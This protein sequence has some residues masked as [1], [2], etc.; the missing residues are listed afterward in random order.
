MQFL[1]FYPI[2]LQDRSMS[3]FKVIDL[4][5]GCGGL[6]CGFKKDFEL[7]ASLEIDKTCCETLNSNSNP[8]ELIINEDINNFQNYLPILDS[9]IN[10]NLD[11]VIGG[12]PCQAYSIAGRINPNN[13]GIRLVCNETYGDLWKINDKRYH[14]LEYSYVKDGDI[15]RIQQNTTNYK[16]TCMLYQAN[17]LLKGEWKPTSI[18][19]HL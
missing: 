19:D 17:E 10:G 3:K 12:P 2:V 1:S 6:S 16:E 5:A 9:K 11:G 4:F 14:P 13:K 8:E 15:A 7:I 18:K